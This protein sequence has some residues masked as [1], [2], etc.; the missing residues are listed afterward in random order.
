LHHY[1]SMATKYYEAC[2][3]GEKVKLKRY[4]Y[5]LRTTLASLWIVEHS[6]MPPIAFQQL[7]PL[8]NDLA[9]EEKV[10]SW[11]SL[12][13]EKEESYLHAKEIDVLNF[14]QKTLSYCNSKTDQFTKH[15]G[16][17]APLNQ[18]FR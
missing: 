5:A 14:I 12:K 2:T 8:M 10:Q 1:L 16:E 18:L 3:E 6:S 9:L 7:L 4:F 15:Q 11:I 17:T 13:A